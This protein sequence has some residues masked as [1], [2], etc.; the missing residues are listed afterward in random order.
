MSSHENA[1]IP[2]QSITPQ[3]IE[4]D[5][6]AYLQSLPDSKVWIDYFR[7]ASHGRTLIR[8]LAGYGAF[9]AHEARSVRR[10][11]NLETARLDSSTRAMAY[12][13]GYPSRRRRATRLR[14][15]VAGDLT[16]MR[17]V[18]SESSV[19]GQISTGSSVIP[20]STTNGQ[21][22]IINE[23][24]TTTLNCVAGRWETYSGTLT[25]REFPELAFVPRNAD[26]AELEPHEVDDELVLVHLTE[27]GEDPVSMNVGDFIEDFQFSVEGTAA[28]ILGTIGGNKDVIVKTLITELV[29][30]FGGSVGDNLVLGKRPVENSTVSIRYLICPD[31]A[32]DEGLSINN[33]N[34]NGLSKNSSALTSAH[35]QET[36][37]NPFLVA[38]PLPADDAEIMKKIVP[39]YF[40]SKRRMVSKT[41]HEAIV[42]AQPEIYD[43]KVVE[44]QCFGFDDDDDGDSFFGYDQTMCQ[45]LGTNR[46]R[47]EYVSVPSNADV[48]GRYEVVLKKQVL[49]DYVSTVYEQKTGRHLEYAADEN[50]PSV[51]TSTTV[52]LAT[53]RDEVA[54][55]VLGSV[56]FDEVANIADLENNKYHYS[57]TTRTITFSTQTETF[58]ATTGS[59]Q[60]HTI[61][62]SN[63][64]VVSLSHSDS[65]ASFDDDPQDAVGDVTADGNWHVDGTTLTYW[66]GMAGDITISMTNVGGA[67]ISSLGTRMYAYKE[68]GTLFFHSAQ[69]GAEIDVTYD[70]TVFEKSVASLTKRTTAEKFLVYQFLD[71][72]I[73]GNAGVEQITSVSS[74]TQGTTALEQVAM[75]ADIDASGT[76][77]NKWFFRKVANEIPLL[78]VRFTAHESL[79]TSA[80]AP[81]DPPLNV[82]FQYNGTTWKRPETGNTPLENYQ[83]LICYVKTL[84]NTSVR[85]PDVENGLLASEEQALKDKLLAHQMLGEQLFFRK[86][87]P[88]DVDVKISMTLTD[89]SFRN[90]AVSLVGDLV[91]S[92]CYVIGGTFDIPRFN[93]EVLA[94]SEVN[95][96]VVQRPISSLRLSDLAY[97]KPGRS[98]IRVVADSTDLPRLNTNED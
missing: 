47:V 78:M 82:R 93:K 67:S 84:S 75:E 54:R 36:T 91:R 34:P 80:T 85:Q 24:G 32:G 96:C 74:V 14:L 45:S 95:E 69:K 83:T 13:L 70:R 92:Q 42:N 30:M 86:A 81:M 77:N 31:I 21:N 29:V 4:R 63:T 37:D 20:V 38:N 11:A 43:C 57:K 52:V 10:E 88:V 79:S 60:T 44:M 7:D 87:R 15:T 61:T 62:T 46:T 28:P 55:I 33:F 16:D 22:L 94:L 98:D 12:T 5:I 72:D 65:G 26:G 39:G 41:D 8:I 25:D 66:T 19:I 89:P 17:G 56:E 53:G 76:V 90:K 59:S 6:L 27:P 40:S 68:Y 71:S 97:F 64:G 50:V 23:V 48:N 35:F 3:S 51:L 73:P 49:R 18:V 2:Q 9:L 58:T 1:L